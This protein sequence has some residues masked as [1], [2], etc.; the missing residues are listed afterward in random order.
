MTSASASPS[1]EMARYGGCTS[2][3]WMNGES[4]PFSHFNKLR[5][6]G[7]CLATA[8]ALYGAG[9]GHAARALDP[10]I[11]CVLAAGRARAYGG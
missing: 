2:N 4:P 8:V 5:S 1:A 3:P 10:G 6:G 9:T 11:P 7:W